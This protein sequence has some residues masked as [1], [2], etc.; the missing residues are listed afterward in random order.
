MEDGEEFDKL[1][2]VSQQDIQNALR[3]GGVS[4]EHL[5][6]VESLELDVLALLSHHVHHQLQV[7]CAAHVAR[8]DGEVT[9]LEQQF[10]EQ[11]EGLQ[12]QP[13]ALK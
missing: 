10:P 12:Q 13:R 7:V 2:A 8:H 4:D 11:L 6:D 1:L 5:E 3:L 9:S